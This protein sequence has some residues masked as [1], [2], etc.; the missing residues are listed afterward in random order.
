[1]CDLQKWITRLFLCISRVT[2][3]PAFWYGRVHWFLLYNSI[4]YFCLPCKPLFCMN[5]HRQLTHDA[6]YLLPFNLWVCLH[7]FIF[8]CIKCIF[9]FFCKLSGLFG[10]VLSPSS[11][12]ISEIICESWFFKYGLFLRQKIDE[13]WKVIFISSLNFTRGD[14]Q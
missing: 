1:M 12:M 8:V 10:Y 6:T 11:G 13:S 9:I 2:G 7:F 14:A 3:L 5:L 4:R